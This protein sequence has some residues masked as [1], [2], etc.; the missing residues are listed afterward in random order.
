LYIDLNLK[1]IFD[2]CKLK[3]TQIIP[4]SSWDGSKLTQY[5]TSQRITFQDL[6]GQIVQSHT[7][8]KETC[9][10]KSARDHELLSWRPC[11]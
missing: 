9:A 7:C 11:T 10:N 8:T 3:S 2:L 1:G 5:L 6:L 4:M